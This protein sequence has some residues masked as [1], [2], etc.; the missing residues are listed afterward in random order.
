MNIRDARQ[1]IIHT[2]KAY[3]SKN[4]DGSYRIPLLRQRP[5]LLIGPPGIGKTAVMEQAA[6]ECGVGFVSYTMTH[7]TRQSAMGLPFIEHHSYNGREYAVT[8]YTMSEIIASVYQCIEE[9]GIQEGLLFLD[10]INCVSET[11]APAML[12]FLQTKMFGNHRLPKGWVLAA[13]GNPPEYNK[14][15]REF[16]IATLDRLKYITIEAD[17]DAWR[18]YALEMNVHGAILAYL[19]TRP[20]QFYLLRQSYT[21]KSFVTARGWE[22]LSC[23]L[24]EYENLNLPVTAELIAQYLHHEELSQDFAGFYY[25]Y[26]QRQ[27]SLPVAAMIAG[28]EKAVLFCNEWL[29]QSS[30]SEQLYLIHLMLAHLGNHLLSWKKSV[31]DQ[32]ML[33]NVLERLDRYQ[34]QEKISDTASA[35]PAF[36]EKEQNILQIRREHG[37]SNETEL[38][39]MQQML[40]LIQKLAYQMRADGIQSAAIVK[41]LNENAESITLKLISMIQNSVR[42]L[43]DSEPAVYTCFLSSFMQN[44]LASSFADKYLPELKNECASRLDF[45]NREAELKNIL[46]NS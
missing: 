3:T 29:I 13:A 37:L 26:A 25:L 36:L 27:K 43:T 2:I 18:A 19:D 21:S 24:L 22:D 35:I 7:H 46:S 44:H 16:D 28:D 34:K 1:E 39:Q 10:E 20:E 4:A 42:F 31:D 30:F 15:V 45:Q 41:E 23:L 38:H 32:K 14:S 17:Y 6:A 5:L 33:L 11:L 40:Y 12:Q 9:T 8:E